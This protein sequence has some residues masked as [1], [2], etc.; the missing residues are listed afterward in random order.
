MLRLH[1]FWNGIRQYTACS[2]GRHTAY[3]I[4]LMAYGIWHTAC[5]IRTASHTAYS[6]RLAAYITWHM[7]S[8][9]IRHMASYGTRHTA[10]GRRLLIAYGLRHTAHTA[11][12]AYGASPFPT[13][14]AFPAPLQ[15]RFRHIIKDGNAFHH[16]SSSTGLTGLASPNSRL[17][18]SSNNVIGKLSLFPNNAPSRLR[19]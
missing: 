15:H 7:V 8:Y 19:P 14:H 2:I 11:Y 3:G 6:I 12:S 4:R 16:I 5:C 13:P 17:T 18:L 1:A 9:G 10:Y